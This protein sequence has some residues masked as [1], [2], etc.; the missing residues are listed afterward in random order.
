MSNNLKL[1]IV[2][3]FSNTIQGEGPRLKSAV[4]IRSGL[5]N[6]TCEGFG[7]KKTAPDG[8]VVTGC[9]TIHAVSS[10]FK[11]KWKFYDKY[12]D[13]VNEINPLVKMANAHDSNKKDIIWTGGEPLIHWKN[14]VMQGTLAYYISRGHKVTVE[15]NASLDIDFFREYQ[16][17]IMFSMS[18]KL[19]CSGMPKSKRI[20]IETITKILENCPDSYLKFVVNPETWENDIIEIREILDNVPYY[21][22]VFLMPMGETREKQM[23]NLPFVFEKCAEYG[24][25][26]SPR[27]HILAFDTRE[28]I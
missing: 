8:S 16:K 27:I 28:G 15:T 19:S 23:K 11:S 17:Q 2:E 9:D 7:C 24:F 5:C 10:K 18:V 14:P 1:P 21:A 26:F 22:N 13:L 12:I 20:N 3:F 6:F 25:S 4:F